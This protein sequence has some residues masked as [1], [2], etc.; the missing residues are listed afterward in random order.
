MPT[1]ITWVSFGIVHRTR[2]VPSTLRISTT[3]TYDLP[4]GLVPSHEYTPVKSFSEPSSALIPIGPA[5][6]TRTTPNRIGLTIPFLG[7]RRRYRVLY[8]TARARRPFLGARHGPDLS[9]S[10]PFSLL[11]VN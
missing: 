11:S 10:D 6:A 7:F 9:G 1:P 4:S 2:Y 8:A 3:P 5:N